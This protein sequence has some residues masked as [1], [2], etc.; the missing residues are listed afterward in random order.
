MLGRHVVSVAQWTFTRAELLGWTTR[1]PA[2]RRSAIED[3]RARYAIP[4]HVLIADGDNRLTVDLESDQSVASART[5]L[6]GSE[7]V[8]LQE[9]IGVAD[10]TFAT[11]PEGG[12][13]CELVVPMR[14]EPRATRPTPRPV[15]GL[16]DTTRRHPMGQRW[17]VVKLYA[18][19]SHGDRVLLGVIRPVARSGTAGLRWFFER[20]RDPDEHVKLVL[21]TTGRA[22]TERVLRTVLRRCAAL[23]A[24]G[25]LVRSTIEGYAPALETFG[26]PDA[27]AAAETVAWR[28]SEAVLQLLA[29]RRL[30]LAHDSRQRWLA[31]AIAFDRFVTAVA[32]AD[33]LGYLELARAGALE[34]VEP[35]DALEPALSRAYRA[36]KHEL[37]AVL[38][39]PDSIGRRIRTALALRDEVIAKETRSLLA[40]A[41]ARSTPHTFEST[42][43]IAQDVLRRLAR[44]RDA[45]SEL[46]IV[47][48]LL[49]RER[50]LVARLGAAEWTARKRGAKL[51]R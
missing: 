33:R 23:E 40:R 44:T 15:L 2:A 16:R 46:A 24:D 26:G 42:W 32:P 12:F 50:S 19:P 9:A 35:S 3:L 13:V 21:R 30:D 43:A 31:Q 5:A 8:L 11:G 20:A 27:M 39:G 29:D 1:D 34:A 6:G 4:R 18:R 48:G 28:D 51:E 25:T 22:A 38:E 14:L 47:D 41:G 36:S 45:E 17:T 49:R 7:L 37:D 10:A